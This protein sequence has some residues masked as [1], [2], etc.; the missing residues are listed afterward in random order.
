MVDLIATSS[1]YGAGYLD[2]LYAN[3]CS[4]ATVC[5][6]NYKKQPS[7]H[8]DSFDARLKEWEQR[9]KGPKEYVILTFAR[10]FMRPS[11]ADNNRALISTLD[12]P[13]N[14]HY[15]LKSLTPVLALYYYDALPR[16]YKSRFPGMGT[17][18]AQSKFIDGLTFFQRNV[19]DRSI[20]EIFDSK[21]EEYYDKYRNFGIK[22]TPTVYIADKAKHEARKK[23]TRVKSQSDIDNSM[24]KSC[25]AMLQ[26]YVNDYAKDPSNLSDI[27][28][29]VFE[30]GGFGEIPSIDSASAKRLLLNLVLLKDSPGLIAA[31]AD[32][33]LGWDADLSDYLL[34]MI[35]RQ[36]LER[37]GHYT[38]VFSTMQKLGLVDD[39][40]IERFTLRLLVTTGLV[41]AESERV[42]SE[43][44]SQNGPGA[45]AEQ[46]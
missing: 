31:F 34:E 3:F 27:A 25:I 45:R 20:E 10:C 6:E 7:L 26:C 46:Q 17:H 28:R 19:A 22:H 2:Y 40:T 29:F 9:E 42:L 5:V 12:M 21:A 15:I 36:R 8:T 35:G 24:K 30:V 16:S 38:Q 43:S 44:A 1:E 14:A 11:V 32:N 37:L 18:N 23:A 39:A 33:R 4:L 13:L 41:R